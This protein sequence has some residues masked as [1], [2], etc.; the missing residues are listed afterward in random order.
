MLPKDGKLRPRVTN[1][2]AS[3]LG[4]HLQSMAL[5]R[6][7]ALMSRG[8][9]SKWCLISVC[10][11]RDPVLIFVMFLPEKNFFFFN[12][13]CVA[14]FWTVT[15]PSLGH[16]PFYWRHTGHLGLSRELGCRDA[17]VWDPSSGEYWTVTMYF[18]DYLWLLLLGGSPSLQQHVVSSSYNGSQAGPLGYCPRSSC[19][20]GHSNLELLIWLKYV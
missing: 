3:R 19:V 16:P 20:P 6:C 5:S 18:T 14:C 1:C 8:I 10:G 2:A 7:I 9:W 13:L 11:R 17:W 15:P 12:P 4:H